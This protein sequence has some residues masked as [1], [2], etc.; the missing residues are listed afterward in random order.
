ML[1]TTRLLT[2]RH[3]VIKTEA[4]TSRLDLIEIWR[5]KFPDIAAV[6]WSNRSITKLSGIGFWLI[7]NGFS[8]ATY[9]N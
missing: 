1:F 2:D 6:T 5:E 8:K 9:F 3:L 7:S 4:Q